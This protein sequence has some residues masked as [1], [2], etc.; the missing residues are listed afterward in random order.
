MY[1][2]HWGLNEWPFRGGLDLRYFFQSPATD[3]ALA[4]I[5]FLVAENRRLGLLLGASGVGKSLLLEIASRELPGSGAQVAKFSL[6]GASPQEMLWQLADGWGLRPRPEE[7]IA[8]LWRKVMDAIAANRYVQLPSV[9]LADDAEEARADTLAMLVRLL[10]ADM[11]P[12]ARLTVVLA[13]RYERLRRLGERLLEVAELRIDLA[14]WDSTQTTFY[15][16][17]ALER[18]GSRRK[19]FT[20]GAAARL[21]ELA[22]GVP[23]R[24]CQLADL[25]LLAG[26]S[27]GAREVDTATVDGVFQELGAIAA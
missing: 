13:S 22:G 5:D 4:R 11:S 17:T 10:Q 9:L 7:G 2:R 14:P 23:R 20:G 19:I 12:H 21:H 25:A 15:L 27:Q 18:A 24:V 16:D 1:L 6:L 8:A 3:E 26:A